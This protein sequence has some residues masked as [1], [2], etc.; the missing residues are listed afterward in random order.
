MGALTPFTQ[1]LYDA[2]LGL[3]SGPGLTGVLFL[4]GSGDRASHL[5]L[6][7]LQIVENLKEWSSQ[8]RRRLTV[9]RDAPFP[10]LFALDTWRAQCAYDVAYLTA[11]YVTYACLLGRCP[12]IPLRLCLRMWAS[13]V[14][15]S[16]PRQPACISYPGVPFACERISCGVELRVHLI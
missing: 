6:V 16:S 10:L 2:V 12:W 9:S 4:D 8:R 7:N 3:P 13:M 5:E 11:Y 15:R 1:A 14:R